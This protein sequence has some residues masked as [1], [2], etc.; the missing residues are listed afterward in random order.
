MLLGP[1]RHRWLRQ[2]APPDFVLEAQRQGRISHRHADQPVA[3]MFS[4]RR[5]VIT[6][7]PVCRTF[8]VSPQPQG[9]SRIVGARKGEAG[10]LKPDF[11]QTS[12]YSENVQVLRCRRNVRGL[13]CNRAWTHSLQS[14]SRLGWTGRGTQDGSVRHARPPCAKAVEQCGQF[15]R[16]RRHTWHSGLE[17]AVRNGPIKSDNG[18]KYRHFWSATH[19][20]GWERSSPGQRANKKRWFPMD[21]GMTQ[22]HPFATRPLLRLH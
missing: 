2:A 14:M 11:A 15:G 19:L 1:R 21:W 20:R 12:A 18:A 16:C 4:S 13:W 10:G 7:H 8:P 22:T 6:G 3:T 9:A 5:R 17:F